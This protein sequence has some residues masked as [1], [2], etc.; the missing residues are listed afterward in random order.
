M[1]KNNL[2][3]AVIPISSPLVQEVLKVKSSSEENLLS[4]LTGRLERFKSLFVEP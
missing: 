4:K 2:W 3:Q 1:L